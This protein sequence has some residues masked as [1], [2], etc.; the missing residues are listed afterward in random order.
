MSPL[1]IRIFTL[2]YLLLMIHQI[3][4]QTSN[5]MI[6][7]SLMI[8]CFLFHIVLII[9]F[10]KITIHSGKRQIWWQV[11]ST[12]IIWAKVVTTFGWKERI[13]SLMRSRTSSLTC[14][15]LSCLQRLSQMMRSSLALTIK[16]CLEV[17]VT[18]L[19][20]RHVLHKRTFDL[21]VPWW[22]HLSR[23]WYSNQS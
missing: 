22:W 2:N 6:N 19:F 5:L 15:W 8:F 16:F 10:K 14:W 3:V 1:F 23:W 17:P 21:R 11:Y 9:F 18:S 12:R 7:Y 4:M 20:Q 13:C